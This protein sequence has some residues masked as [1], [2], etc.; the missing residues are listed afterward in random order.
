[1]TRTLLAGITGALAWLAGMLLFFIPAQAVLANPSYQSAKFLDVMFR[2]EPLPRSAAGLWII[3]LGLLVIATLHSAVYGWIRPALSGSW[4]RRG[5]KFGV[6]A[7]ALMVPWFEFYLPWNV[8][9]EPAPLVL[10]ECLLWLGTLC[11]TGLG[12][13]FVHEWRRPAS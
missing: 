12:I 13:A 8:M 9:W 7:W 3:L 2:I 6:I 11:V 1:M 10:L 4:I 5:M